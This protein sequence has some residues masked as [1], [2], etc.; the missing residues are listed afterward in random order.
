MKK[1]NILRQQF[2]TTT[3]EG[4]DLTDTAFAD[5]TMAQVNA[6]LRSDLGT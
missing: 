6:Q 5:R 3:A 1:L 2:N 4:V